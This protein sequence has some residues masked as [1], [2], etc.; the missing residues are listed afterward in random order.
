MSAAMN[1]RVRDNLLHVAD[2]VSDPK[3]AQAFSDAA[4]G[5][6]SLKDLLSMSE[7]QDLI[8]EGF[9][10]FKSYRAGLTDEQKQQLERDGVEEAKAL[11][12]I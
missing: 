4:K 9:D 8:D 1:R 7:V 10:R 6:I 2:N 12:I 11:G 3:L 5:R